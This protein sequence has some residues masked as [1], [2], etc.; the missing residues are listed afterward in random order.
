M[1]ETQSKPLVEDEGPITITPAPRTNAQSSSAQNDSLHENANGSI[2]LQPGYRYRVPAVELCAMDSGLAAPMFA[3]LQQLF[4]SYDDS[5]YE[6]QSHI[7]RHMQRVEGLIAHCKTV[8]AK[9]DSKASLNV[10]DKIIPAMK[11]NVNDIQKKVEKLEGDVENL[12]YLI[13]KL[14]ILRSG[15]DPATPLPPKYLPS[16]PEPTIPHTIPHH[17][18][19]SASSTTTTPIPSPRANATSTNGNCIAPG[20]TLSDGRAMCSCAS[21]A[22]PNTADGALD[23]SV[24]GASETVSER[25]YEEIPGGVSPEDVNGNNEENHDNRREANPNT[26][27]NGTVGDQSDAQDAHENGPLNS[28]SG[29]SIGNEGDQHTDTGS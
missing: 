16:L 20:P 6:R 2:S 4:W 5:I 13:E 18:S 29:E 27:E 23:E 10:F 14:T 9:H 28:V 21:G 1:G 15:G 25:L 22:A 8:V 11:D 3:Q 24:E 26:E 7:S 17:S 12:S 19:L